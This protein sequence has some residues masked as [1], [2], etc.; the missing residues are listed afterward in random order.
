MSADFSVRARLGAVAEVTVVVLGTLSAVVALAMSPLG[1]W[2]AGALRR[3]FLEYA[4]MLGLPLAFTFA[5]GRSLTAHGIKMKD[6][7]S[8]VDIALRCLVAVAVSKV[9][10]A[11][12][13]HRRWNG[14]LLMS[15]IEVGLLFWVGRILRGKAAA[16]GVVLTALVLPL[17]AGPVP[18]HGP[19]VGRAASALVFYVL[20]LGPGE[21]VLFRGYVQSRLNAV[22]GRPYRFFGTSWGVGALIAA[23]L[24][25]AMH[26]ANLASLGTGSWHPEWWWGVWTFFAGLVASVV[27]EKS[28]GVLA[29]ALLHGVPQGIA[30]AVL[31]R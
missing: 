19:P 6:L 21:E 1:R 30:W 11:L 14:A 22:F 26:V 5:M 16:T 20:F 24:F 18:L 13:D 9:P 17:L 12:L 23:V 27:R 25:G 10:L 31:G 2:E 7:R 15:A 8:Q 28:G 3:P 29:P 4:L